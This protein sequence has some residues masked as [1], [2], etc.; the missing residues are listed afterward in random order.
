[1]YGSRIP[2][3]WRYAADLHFQHLLIP[4]EQSKDDAAGGDKELHPVATGE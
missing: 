1:L 2:A 4:E 3:A